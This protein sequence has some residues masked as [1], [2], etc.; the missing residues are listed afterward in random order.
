MAGG[1][2]N[3]AEL[4]YAVMLAV[5]DFHTEFM[6]SK[7]S[8]VQASVYSDLIYVTSSRSGSIPA[9]DELARSPEG[10]MLLQ[11]YHQAM[12]D[13]CRGFLKDRIEQAIGTRIQ[14]I[15]TDID[16]TAGR[17]TFAITLLE[18]LAQLA[19]H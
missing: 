12:F 8:R 1:A 19:T 9:E 14:H 4:E 15:I 7:Y 3:K 16:P 6:K 2:A 5:L 11:Q 13:S 18:P 10:R 17:C